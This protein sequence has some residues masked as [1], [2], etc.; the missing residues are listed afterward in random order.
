MPIDCMLLLIA[1]SSNA[2]CNFNGWRIGLKVRLPSGVVGAVETSIKLSS[3][4][5]FDAGMEG[6]LFAYIFAAGETVSSP[7]GQ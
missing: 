5:T 3:E 6:C 7:A 2:S 1:A 4:S